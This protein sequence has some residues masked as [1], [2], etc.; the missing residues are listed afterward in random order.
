MRDNKKLM[1]ALKEAM[2]INPEVEIIKYLRFICSVDNMNY[3]SDREIAELIEYCNS[4]DTFDDYEIVPNNIFFNF[5]D[6]YVNEEKYD[7]TK[8]NEL[9]A[10][11]RYKEYTEGK[12]FFNLYEKVNMKEFLERFE[13]EYVNADDYCDLTVIN[14]KDM[15]LN[16]FP[17]SYRHMNGYVVARKGEKYIAK[18]VYLVKNPCFGE[19]MEYVMH[20]CKREYDECLAIAIDW[21]ESP[22]F[23]DYTRHI[24]Y[25]LK[26]RE[27]DRVV[28]I[29]NDN[30][31]IE[32]FHDFFQKANKIISTWDGVIFDDGT[33]D[34]E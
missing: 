31:T 19:L 15:F 34:L 33:C 22:R 30:Q 1:V 13:L 17:M 25:G 3:I 28:E 24:M 18:H 23:T 6:Y 4:N 11:G 8:E 10:Y 2:E 29:Y 7:F 12:V 32:K 5:I 9:M 20:E 14:H 21:C 26:Y 27:K 16:N